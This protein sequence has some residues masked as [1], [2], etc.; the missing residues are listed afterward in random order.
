MDELRTH[1]H[2]KISEFPDEEQ[3]LELVQSLRDDQTWGW[4][5]AALYIYGCRPSE[6]FSL[7]PKTDGTA[8][9]LTIKQQKKI[10]FWRTALALPQELIEPLN[11]FEISKPVQYK[12]AKQYDSLE[13]KSWTDRWNKWLK[14]NCGHQSLHLYDIRHAWAI[15]S[16]RMNLPT[17]AGATSMGHEVNVHVKTYISA[18]SEVDTKTVG[19]L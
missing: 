12:K 17:G 13:A 8:K 3:L 15:R 6:I 18:I 4:C 5:T 10:P 14:K 11:L 2:P 9:V 16:I 1:Y 7:Q 19:D